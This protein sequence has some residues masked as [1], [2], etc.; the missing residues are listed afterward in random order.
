MTAFVFFCNVRI[1]DECIQ[2]FLFIC[3]GL[4]SQCQCNDYVTVFGFGMRDT[5]TH[6]HQASVHS[7][8]VVW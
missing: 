3:H 8:C 6:A 2:S 5:S 7:R 1:I 4:I